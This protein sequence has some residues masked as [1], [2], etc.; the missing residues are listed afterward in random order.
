MQVALNRQLSLDEAAE[1][2]TL[3]QL[4]DSFQDALYAV[5]LQREQL[6]QIEDNFQEA[7]LAAKAAAPPVT[8]E[9]LIQ[10]GWK[11]MSC[12]HCQELCQ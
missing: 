8:L 10:Q 6:V 12:S 11:F 1:F 5:P 2:K 9:K 3:A 7:L 4:E